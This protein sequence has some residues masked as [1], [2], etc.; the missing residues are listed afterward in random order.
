MSKLSEAA[1]TTLSQSYSDAMVSL[2]KISSSLYSASESAANVEFNQA[3]FD[4]VNR[5]HQDFMQMIKDIEQKFYKDFPQ[6]VQPTIEEQ[7]IQKVWEEI[8]KFEN[9]LEMP[10]ELCI[11]EYNYDTGLYQPKLDVTLEQI[12]KR[13]SDFQSY[14]KY[15]AQKRGISEISENFSLAETMEKFLHDNGIVVDNSDIER[16]NHVNKIESELIANSSSVYYDFGE[17]FDFL[18]NNSERFSPQTLSKA[19]AILDLL[20]DIEVLNVK[21]KN[22]ILNEGLVSYSS[23]K[24]LPFANLHMRQNRDTFSDTLDNIVQK[25]AKNIFNPLTEN[26]ITEINNMKKIIDK[27]NTNEDLI[28]NNTLYPVYELALTSDAFDEPY[29]FYKLGSDSVEYSKDGTALTFETVGDARDYAARE[30]MHYSIHP[31]IDITINKQEKLIERLQNAENKEVSTEN[32]DIRGK[33]QKAQENMSI[34][35][36]V[37][38][39]KERSKTSDG[40]GSNDKPKKL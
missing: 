27:I 2:S 13:F 12:E 15:Q 5:H 25:H 6:F 14:S 28:K 1:S 23:D 16:K 4:K 38:L 10:A 3:E 7:R 31:G 21:R 32:L 33:I 11:T 30:S 26:Q 22:F 8:N 39:A 34:R 29:A 37:A 9:V 40:N 18:Q 24:E 20:G 35:D 19:Y 36:R 17:T